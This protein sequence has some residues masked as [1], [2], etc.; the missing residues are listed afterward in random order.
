VIKLG[1]SWFGKKD[2]PSLGKRGWRSAAG[3][4]CISIL[5]FVV[6]IWEFWPSL[7]NGFVNYDDNLYVT[8]NPHV[9]SG[10]TSQS[11]AWAFRGLHGEQTYWHPLTWVS[12]M[13]DCQLYGLNAWGHH[14]T[15]TLWHALNTTLVFLVFRRM[16]GAFWRSAALAALFGLHPLQVDTVAWV[17]ER[18]NLL[19]A[20]FWLLALWAYTAYAQA[21]R[22]TSLS[23][24]G[25]SG[26]ATAATKRGTDRPRDRARNLA[27]PIYYSLAL[28]LFLIGLMCKPVAVTLPFVFLLL[29]YWPLGRAAELGAPDAISDRGPVWKYLI[30]EKVPFFVFAAGSCLITTLAH[31]GMGLLDPAV[32]PPFAIRF[33]NALVSYVRYLAKALWP[34]N[35]CVFYP[36]PDTWPA[37]TAI[38]CGLCLAA[39]S[40]LLL[41]NIAK[42]PYLLIGWLWFL[43]VLVP[44]IGLIQVGAQAMADRF[45]C[46][47]LLGLLIVAVWGTSS[48]AASWRMAALLLPAL[49]VGTIL[50]FCFETRQQLETWKDAESLWRHA[51]FVTENNKVAHCNLGVALVRKRALEE[52]IEQLEESIRL[53]MAVSGAHGV[54]AYALAEK[55]RFTEAIQE[56]ETALRL[57]PT[58][59]QT[60]RNYAATL[61]RL[62]RTG[63]AIQTYLAA[64]RL[65]PG[66]WE[67]HEAFGTVLAACGQFSEAAAEFR[68][69]LRLRP[70][71]TSA[72]RMLDS[73]L[74][75][76]LQFEKAAEPYCQALRKDPRN[77]RAHLRL[78]QV[79]LRAGR[80]EEALVHWRES[81]RLAPQWVE[82]VNNLAWVLATDPAAPLQD[83]TEPL[84]LAMRALALS[85]TNDVRVLD[86][87]GAAYAQAGRFIEASATARQA[88]AL[89][90]AQ[91]QAE[92][93]KQIGQR[94]TLYDMRRPYREGL[95]AK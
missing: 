8:D 37:W 10:L 4:A 33:E 65:K 57:D 86:T 83:P 29:D 39:I 59:T 17:S 53:G 22:P 13:L 38:T 93:G 62:G 26:D 42:R 35:L 74:E 45:M 64:L 68:E 54:L 43:G 94:A 9:Q 58:D 55:E 34:A 71:H 67:V 46:V 25:K 61:V 82:P 16:S 3:T 89:A 90:A 7:R 24:R 78:G 5:L 41:S 40:V 81:A 28:C 21:Q 15:S 11:L 95:G 32:V 23:Q 87:L 50:L 85:G 27:A 56:F 70:E 14:L 66:S 18:K 79:L 76:E 92:L 49:T 84:Q 44:F 80:L 73:V 52:A 12:H 47:P 77:A 51:L 20:F 69:V 72:K 88:A 75:Q 30:L 31:R 91:G 6:V 36:Y 60:L 48:I 2:L 19:S 63:E 1:T